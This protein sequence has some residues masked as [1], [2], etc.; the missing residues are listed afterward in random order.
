MS[1]TPEELAELNGET[2]GGL[3]PEEMAELNG[4]SG[5]LTP[6]E[7]AE[8]NGQASPSFMDDL[9]AIGSGLMQAATQGA[10]N[11][12]I[13]ASDVVVDLG[14]MVTGRDAEIAKRTAELQ[15][16]YSQSLGAE[17]I[18]PGFGNTVRAAIDATLEKAFPSMKGEAPKYEPLPDE[19]TYEESIEGVAE[20]ESVARQAAENWL[21][22]IKKLWVDPHASEGGP[23]MRGLKTL[24]KGEEAVAN[25]LL[26]AKYYADQLKE[27]GLSQ[28]DALKILS[29]SELHIHDLVD[30]WVPASGPTARIGKGI[31]GF[32]GDVFADPL[33]YVTMGTSRAAEAIA[34]TGMKASG[35]STRAMKASAFTLPEIDK[36]GKVEQANAFA[37][38]Q[39]IDILTQEGEKQAL[40]A[41]KTLDNRTAQGL[42]APTGPNLPAQFDLERIEQAIIKAEE[43]LGGL[44][45]VAPERAVDEIAARAGYQFTDPVQRELMTVL[46]NAQK[47][48][49]GF[50]QGGK[51]IY[52]HVPF[53]RIGYELPLQGAI[54][55]PVSV[56]AGIKNGAADAIWTGL[57][58]MA[59][60]SSP[61][62]AF[63]GETTKKAVNSVSNVYRNLVTE[64]SRPI[65]NWAKNQYYAA[66][67][68]FLPRRA[69]SYKEMVE[70]GLDADEKALLL[71]YLETEPV[72]T[73]KGFELELEKSADTV[74]TPTQVMYRGGPLGP[75]NK[76][77]FIE[78]LYDPDFPEGFDEISKKLE[79]LDRERKLRLVSTDGK[80]P[81]MDDLDK[82]IEENALY[83]EINIQKVSKKYKAGQV[84]RALKAYDDAQAIRAQMTPRTREV[85]DKILQE[86]REMLLRYKAE[87]MPTFR[88]LN[89]IDAKDG[90]ATG[91]VKHMVRKDWIKAVQRVAR[92]RQ[93]GEAINPETLRVLKESTI[94][95]EVMDAALEFIEADENL[96][97]LISGSEFGR[98]YRGSIE[99]ANKRSME[100]FNEPMFVD[101][102]ILAHASRMLDMEKN[103]A[104]RG[105]AES[106]VPLAIKPGTKRFPR[107]YVKVN[108]EEKFGY[109]FKDGVSY[110]AFMPDEIVK[111][112]EANNGVIYLPEDV[113]TRFLH[114]FNQ[115]AGKTG[116][117]IKTSE[118]MN[119]L[120][121]PVLLYGTGYLGQNFFSNLLTYEQVG[122]SHRR[123]LEALVAAKNPAKFGEKVFDFGPD[124]KLTG[125]EL[126]QV[127]RENGVLGTSF[128]NDTEQIEH[129]WQGLR[130]ASVYRK[131]SST[132]KTAAGKLS[133]YEYMARASAYTDD[134]FKLANFMSR[135]DEGY[136]IA[137]AV[138]HTNLWF[139]N[140]KDVSPNLQLLRAVAPFAQFTVKTAERMKESVKKLDF[141][142]L[143]MPA[144][145]HNVLDGAFV[146]DEETRRFLMEYTPVWSRDQ[147]LGPA[148]PGGK[149]VMF[150]IPWAS[151]T[152]QALLNPTDNASP[153][154]KLAALG[155][156][157]WAE[158]ENPNSPAFQA[159]RMGMDEDYV[160]DNYKKFV[161][162]A[163]NL[164]APPPLKEAAAMIQMQNPDRER[165]EYWEALGVGQFNQNTAPINMIAIDANA[166][167]AS[168]GGAGPARGYNMAMFGKYLRENSDLF[169]ESF[170][171]GKHDWSQQDNQLALFKR[172]AMYGQFIKSRFRDLSFGVA[173]I[174]D[175][176][177]NF[178]TNYGAMQRYAKKLDSQIKTEMA[179]LSPQ[180]YDPSAL[181]DQKRLDQ[182]IKN[183]QG[184]LRELLID[185]MQV[186]TSAEALA[187]TYGYFISRPQEANGLLESMREAMGARPLSH[188][189]RIELEQQQE[190]IRMNNKGLIR[191]EMN[192]LMDEEGVEAV[193]EGLTAPVQ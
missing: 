119:S 118:T 183:S 178:I 45:T 7:L 50:A 148:L 43:S 185:K 114:I 54:R 26:V 56:I 74:I 122:G 105:L 5:D 168:I 27:G 171:F 73:R 161:K 167:F 88:P 2:S 125:S 87:G 145:V 126:I 131:K 78:S 190:I 150:E 100:L 173:R 136:S 33:T 24:G 188:D 103:L 146:E 157:I 142:T 132:L 113:A 98:K 28:D 44:L 128:I 137:G 192:K 49:P 147:I 59:E 80:P 110:D 51:S 106:L 38:G 123:M 85:A 127:A 60:A 153:L 83:T 23:L 12:G 9:K 13:G 61:S 96:R 37:R 164:F 177:R 141:L 21:K 129:V 4:S 84:E 30:M 117:F 181:T 172:D 1:L 25:S 35:V 81:A 36:L 63:V 95:S 186:Q 20:G 89:F 77:E 66:Q 16:Q 79:G 101:D 169:Y 40:Q 162:T 135:L 39:V 176:D 112:A 58:R 120:Y 130:D 139:Y 154:F 134:S 11:L 158:E 47:G 170:F 108:L 62:V 104:L 22:G 107:G 15:N 69:Q 116:A 76:K 115:Q 182:M 57:D 75:V 72:M 70:A 32:V 180:L 65:F 18:L 31:S 121:R 165:N 19:K 138:E 140:F 143:T 160:D 179:K 151:N 152:A 42:P 48:M 8:L 102:P 6:E 55:A 133:G 29:Q 187:A 14:K 52:L 53:T 109:K 189:E 3:T 156:T 46:G 86:N 174:S 93:A 166:D 64:T 17:D 92:Q 155:Y 149:Y 41:I 91:Y 82:F 67:S 90:E 34:M 175:M 111:M 191:Q 124:L 144:K 159:I 68:E 10:Q 184:R 99:A 163:V 97:G 94:E 193:S 71:R